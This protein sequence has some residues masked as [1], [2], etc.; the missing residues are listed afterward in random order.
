MGH[1]RGIVTFKKECAND[2]SDALCY[3]DS[4]LSNEGFCS[5][6]YFHS[7][8]G[9]YF[10]MGEG[11]ARYQLLLAEYNAYDI[12]AKLESELGGRYMENIS[13]Q[14][15]IKYIKE[16]GEKPEFVPDPKHLFP[17]HSVSIV[18]RNIYENL[19]VEWLGIDRDDEDFWDLDHEPVD[20]EFIGNKWIVVFY[21]HV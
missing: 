11:D 4:F 5:H 14:F 15:F 13:L 6:G 2:E 3:V 8:I 21:Y 20:E 16:R 19:L 9:E 17:E 7:G 12:M 18:T 10:T 1:Y